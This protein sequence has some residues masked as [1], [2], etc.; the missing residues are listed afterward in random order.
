MTGKS[1]SEGDR[2]I[3]LPHRATVEE[4]YQLI[5]AFNRA[6]RQL[7]PI[8][9]DCGS[10]THF[11]PFGMALLAAIVALRR[12][13]KRTTHLVLP[14]DQEAAHFIQEVG[15]QRFVLGEQTGIGTLEIREM[16]ALDPTYTRHVTDMLIR[17]VPGVTA[18]NSYPIELCLNE[19]LQNV[20][21]WSESPIGCTV[22]TRWYHKTRS[23]R[24][25]VVDL[26]IGIPAALRRA[27]V[28]ELQRASDA[29]VIEAAVMQ[30]KLTSR[31]NQRGGIGLKLVR[32]VVRT[33]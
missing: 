25:S 31:A 24:I 10:V 7:A 12:E 13:T 8:D 28:R 23:V 18:E 2:S 11:G 20:F 15:L 14:E 29:A 17:G 4:S 19:L 5:E 33:H 22:L 1:G 16:H 26:G 3:K 32:E 6:E 30:P 21:E 9:L 27:R